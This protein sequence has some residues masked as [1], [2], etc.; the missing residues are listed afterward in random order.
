MS[1]LWTTLPTPPSPDP[2]VAVELNPLE[3][4]TIRLIRGLLQLDPYPPDPG[5]VHAVC[6]AARAAHIDGLPYNRLAVLST[7]YP[8]HHWDAA[9]HIHETNRRCDDAR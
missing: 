1:T 5:V 6:M 7:L 9:D 4:D 3:L 8:T 2:S